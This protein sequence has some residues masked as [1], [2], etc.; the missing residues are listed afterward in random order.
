MK[1]WMIVAIV[2]AVGGIAYY[3]WRRGELPVAS[4]EELE[5]A[6]ALAAISGLAPAVGAEGR[7]PEQQAMQDKVLIARY[8]ATQI[9]TEEGRTTE[10]IRLAAMV[11]G[12]SAY[13]GVSYEQAKADIEQGYANL[14]TAEAEQVARIA[15]ALGVP[16]AEIARQR[17]AAR[18]AGFPI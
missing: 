3:L 15:Q 4:Q 18:A 2:A 13:K 9:A 14:A 16:E 12:V 7:T 11:A 8:R 1:G 17:A 5:A 10:E 6:R